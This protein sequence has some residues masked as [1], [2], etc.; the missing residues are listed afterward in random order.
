LIVFGHGWNSNPGVYE[1]LL[2]EWAQ[3]GYLVAA[4][5][6]PDSSNLLPGTPISDYGEQA[7]DLSFVITAMLK[8][9]AGPVDPQK[10]VVAGHSDGGPTSR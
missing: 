3:A 5:V 10:I 4:P 1:Q 8:G 7:E 2:D 6:F 9:P